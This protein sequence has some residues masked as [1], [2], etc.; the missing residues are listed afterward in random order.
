M[1]ESNDFGESIQEL[2]NVL[3]KILKSQKPGN[4]DLSSLINK[5]DLNL[6]LCFFTFLPMCEEEMA[7]LEEELAGSLDADFPAEA[8]ELKFELS[9]V[10]REF[11][12][13]YGLKF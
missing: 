12:K 6:N 5:K 10:D 7:D 2:L 1:K 3:K 13:K 4:L 8:E 9:N 11:L